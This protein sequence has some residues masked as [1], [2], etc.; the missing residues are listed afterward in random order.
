LFLLADYYHLE[1]GPKAGLELQLNLLKCGNENRASQAMTEA[2]VAAV[3]DSIVEIQR[4][5]I[6]WYCEHNGLEYDGSVPPADFT[7]LQKEHRNM[8]KAVLGKVSLKLETV[9]LCPIEHCPGFRRTKVHTDPCV[10]C[11][12]SDYFYRDDHGH[13]GVCIL[14][15]FPFATLIRMMYADP[16]KARHLA[17]TFLACEPEIYAM[18][19]VYGES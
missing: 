12:K 11:G 2:T 1:A 15:Y 16:L 3:Q 5:G 13:E 14:R 4:A 17:E 18:S 6:Q 7:E 8:I 9:Y 19:S 10:T